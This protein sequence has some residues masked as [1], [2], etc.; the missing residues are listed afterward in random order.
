MTESIVS[1]LRARAKLWPRGNRFEDFSEGQAF[2]HHWGRTLTDADNMLFTALTMHYNPQHLNAEI[3]RE[4][5]HE[6]G[7]PVAPLL[8]FNAV[9]GMSVEDL[10]EGGG[11]FLGVE[12]CVF[13]VPV[14]SGDTLRASSVVVS[15]R[16]SKKR[17]EFGIVT[18]ATR[19]INQ[20]GDE[21]IRFERSNLVSRRNPVEEPR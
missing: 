20:R 8:V 21:V 19:G 1:N 12:K 15:V 6:T 16:E 17:P 18:W 2:S 5:G 13:G 10:S 11:P 3:A 14:Y 4:N 9:F 7:S